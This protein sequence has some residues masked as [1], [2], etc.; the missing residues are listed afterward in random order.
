MARE[1]ASFRTIGE[2]LDIFDILVHVYKFQDLSLPH[3]LIVC[4]LC[5]YS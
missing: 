1:D 4:A 5:T 3:S 2:K